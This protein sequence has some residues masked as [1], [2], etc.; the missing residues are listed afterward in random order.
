MLELLR[1]GGLIEV[2]LM[3]FV[4]LGS[5]KPWRTRGGMISLKALHLSINLTL[6]GV[7]NVNYTLYPLKL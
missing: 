4:L 5:H 6:S 2:T 3:H 7:V 1:F